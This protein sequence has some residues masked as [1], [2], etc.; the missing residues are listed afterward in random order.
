MDMDMSQEGLY[1]ML[2]KSKASLDLNGR[3]IAEQLSHSEANI[4]GKQKPKV[5]SKASHKP[6]E[7][8]HQSSDTEQPGKNIVETGYEPSDKKQ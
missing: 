2:K 1:G 4:E 6:T 7:L 5:T 3:F 8:R